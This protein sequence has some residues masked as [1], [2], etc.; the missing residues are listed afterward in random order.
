MLGPST[1]SVTLH[2]I[3]EWTGVFGS[4][5]ALFSSALAN[6]SG[7]GFVFGGGCFS[8]HGVA[9]SS[10]SARFTLNSYTVQ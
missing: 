5:A 10:G 1:F 3:A 9:V 4:N 8:G 6:V 7:V 2:D